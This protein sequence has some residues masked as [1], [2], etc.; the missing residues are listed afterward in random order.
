MIKYILILILIRLQTIKVLKYL[1]EKITYQFGKYKITY[2]ILFI[3]KQ[4]TES[5]TFKI[6]DLGL[7]F[8]DKSKYNSDLMD[9]ANSMID[10]K[11]NH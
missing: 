8:G 5:S 1:F 9:Y 4:L 10:R 3:N 11:S 2:N 7:F 6:E